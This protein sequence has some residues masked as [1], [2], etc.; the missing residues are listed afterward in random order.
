VRYLFAAYD[1]HS[2]RLHGRLRKHKN[3]DEVLGFFKQIRMR[4]P[5]SYGSTS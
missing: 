3:A 1:V 4:Y 5:R 2:D